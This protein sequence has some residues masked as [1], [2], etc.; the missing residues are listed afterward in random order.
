MAALRSPLIRFIPIQERFEVACHL[1]AHLAYT[2]FKIVPETV[3][4]H[5]TI[6]L[7][8]IFNQCLSNVAGEDIEKSAR[9]LQG[10]IDMTSHAQLKLAMKN[11]M[12]KTFPNNLGT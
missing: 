10:I 11:T 6:I 12:T 3:Q 9:Y 4:E 7:L 1:L 2:A 5:V 8:D